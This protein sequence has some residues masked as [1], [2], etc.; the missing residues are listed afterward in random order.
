MARVRNRDRVQAIKGDSMLSLTGKNTYERILSGAGKGGAG[1][2]YNATGWEADTENK[3]GLHK[4]RYTEPL[5]SVLK[6]WRR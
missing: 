6:S 3:S 1:A 4:K 5:L 2:G